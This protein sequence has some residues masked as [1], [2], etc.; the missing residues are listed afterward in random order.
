MGWI[1]GF[2]T[3]AGLNF[4][5][6]LCVGIV[7]YIVEKIQSSKRHKKHRL[8]P[9]PIT[10]NDV[11]AIVPAHNEELSIRKTL[12]ALLEVLPRK[13]I[14]VVSDNSSDRTVEIV[15][16][17]RVRCLDLRPNRGK[18]RAL[19]NIMEEYGLLKAYKAIL[20]NDADSIV[21]KNFI[22]NALPMFRDP[23]IA[24]VTPHGLTEK[25]KYGFREM[26]YIAYRIR[27]WR[28]IQLGMRFGQTWKLTNVSYIIPGSYS[29][30]RTS[31]LKKIEI[32]APGL[33]I[34]DF[35]MTFE[36]HKKKLGKI[37]YN[38][39]L[40][41]THQEPY[42]LRDYIKQ[43]KRWNVGF[44][45]T[46]KKNGVWPSFF[47]LATGS[48]LIELT[49][50]AIFL[51]GTPILI[52]MFF[53]NSFEPISVPYVYGRLTLLDLFI[54]VFFMDY[55]SSVVIAVVEKKPIILFYA[56]GFIF[57]RYV[58]SI[59]YLVSIP[60]AFTTSY[61]GIWKSPGRK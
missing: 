28:I 27:L 57:L 54:G 29:I 34:E 12:T 23:E 21:D 2:F 7:R 5:F 9:N 4:T 18:A 55:L 13:S 46:V 50:Y 60:I 11:A 45:Q 33:I 56:L 15:R 51:L 8:S 14:Y 61:E 53:L 49:M 58:D 52:L 35:N 31:V 41:A 19:V 59:I 17:I 47:W 44:F 42:T 1:I 16:S 6:W 36:V 24:A 38:P 30:Y 40:F 10:L 48:F 39:S 25:R 43:V 37:G 32:D 20:I 26:Y 22:K 3:L